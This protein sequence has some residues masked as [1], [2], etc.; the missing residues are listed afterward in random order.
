M[1]EQQKRKE[2]KKK[3]NK[4]D[5]MPAEGPH[6]CGMAGLRRPHTG[7]ICVIWLYAPLPWRRAAAA[8]A[9]SVCQQMHDVCDVLEDLVWFLSSA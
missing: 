8:G 4:K 1:G 6:A 7:Y 5:V 9:A 2:G 3:K